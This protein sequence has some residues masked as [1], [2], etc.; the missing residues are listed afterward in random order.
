MDQNDAQLRKVEGPIFLFRVTPTNILRFTRFFDD[1]TGIGLVLKT[2]YTGT[3][4]AH[5]IQSYTSPK[6]DRYDA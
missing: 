3:E 6:M 5:K 4:S 1:F 2:Y